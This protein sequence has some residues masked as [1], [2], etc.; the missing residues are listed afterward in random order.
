[1]LKNAIVLL[2][3]GQPAAENERK[4]LEALVFHCGGDLRRIIDSPSGSIDRFVRHIERINDLRRSNLPAIVVITDVLRVELTLLRAR[5]QMCAAIPEL[6]NA[7]W[8]IFAGTECLPRL[9]TTL[10]EFSR[11][12]A[13]D[14]NE[15]RLCIT[16]SG[17]T[18][19]ILSPA[20]TDILRL[21]QLAQ[22][23]HENPYVPSVSGPRRTVSGATFAAASSTKKP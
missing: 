20:C 3:N 12:E 15:S 21:K 22:Q 2:P 14:G 9:F 17:D 5:D 8:C 7:L 6:K 11:M 4:A 13:E 23:A 1:M 16:S 10:R 18:F 19:L